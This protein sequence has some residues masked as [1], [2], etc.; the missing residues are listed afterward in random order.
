M[1]YLQE[2]P[3]QKPRN[4]DHTL[5]T[6]LYADI[7]DYP[8][9]RGE[10]VRWMIFGG[11]PVS[12]PKP[13][14]FL[15]GRSNIVK[16]RRDRAQWQ[17]EK[18]KIAAA[19]AGIL[20]RIPTVQLVGVTG[21]LAMNN[22]RAE[23]DIDLFIIAARGTLWVTRILSV[24]ALWGMRRRRNA[25]HVTN[26][27]CLNMFMTE[28]HLEVTEHDLFAA[29]EAL[30][31]KPLWERGGIYRAFLKANAWVNR[32]LPNAKPRKVVSIGAT[33]TLLFRIFEPLAKN[34]QLWYMSRHRTREVI[35]GT[36]LRFHPKDARVWVKKK[37]SA[38]LRRYHTPLDIVFY[39]R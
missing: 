2:L 3:R 11:Q 12:P 23:D 5:L 25:V 8:L 30:Q 16:V 35:T 34:A 17:P 19:A 31:M 27:V 29:H 4:M 24:I 14:Y 9:T 7:F 18:W 10:L 32:F 22:A 15:P 6:V 38:R 21:G 28:D 37:L 20:S 13:Y 33:H 26:K 39:G 1:D 36:T